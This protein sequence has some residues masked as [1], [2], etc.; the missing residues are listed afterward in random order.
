MRDWLFSEMSWLFFAIWSMIVV[1]VSYAAFRRD[2][3]PSKVLSPS[4][5]DSPRTSKTDTTTR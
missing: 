4:R 3:L 1:A 2:L 5:S